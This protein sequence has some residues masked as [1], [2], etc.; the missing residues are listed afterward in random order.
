MSAILDALAAGRGYAYEV[1][2]TNACGTVTAAPA[3]Q[4]GTH[5]YV[6]VVVVGPGTVTFSPAG[7]R[8]RGS[9]KYA[10][11]VL[12]G[13][14]RTVVPDAGARFVRWEAETACY[15]ERPTCEIGPNVH[16]RVIP[17]F[18]AVG[19]TAAPAPAAPASPPP[20][21]SDPAPVAPA[22]GPPATPPAV[23]QSNVP[24]PEAEL[25]QCRVPN[26]NGLLL[27]QARKRLREANCAPGRVT[28]VYSARVRTG[29]V[30]SQ[31]RT[32]DTTLPSG[33]RVDLVV[34]RGARK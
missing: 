14:Q 8:C 17:H 22:V 19:G 3:T 27:R 5:G 28:Y 2:A 6:E 12:G 29:R 1:R 11:H 23:A 24:Q 20:A 9:C 4:F 13:Q 25:A 33:T 18:E 16:V 7:I 32:P 21:S 15:G 31:A 10:A 26:V 34:S 30:A